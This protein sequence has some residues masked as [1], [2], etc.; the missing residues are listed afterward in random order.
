MAFL[1]AAALL[2]AAPSADAKVILAK[3]N[4]KKV[5]QGEAS[6]PRERSAPAEKA[7][8]KAGGGFAF[9]TPSIGPPTG[10]L[11]LPGEL[12]G[13]GKR[14]RMGRVVPQAAS[15]SPSPSHLLSSHL[16]SS[17]S[18]HFFFF[19]SLSFSFFSFFFPSP[20]AI[21]GIAGVAALATTVDSKFVDF[22]D[23]ATLR[24][25]N[26]FAGYEPA[27]KGEGGVAP[28]AAPAKAKKSLFKKK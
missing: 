4:P 13:E 28:R 11:A 10:V 27:L 17:S 6:T 20:G 25:C 7:A 19:L 23:K 24:D 8:K 2:L 22:I 14:E 12:E 21:L 18:I 26:N 15:P 9:V 3:S 5:F 1:A 16:L